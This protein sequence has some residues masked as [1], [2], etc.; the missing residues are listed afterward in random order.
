MNKIRVRIKS[1]IKSESCAFVKLESLQS[2]A[3][4]S[5]LLLDFSG[6]L[7]LGS[8]CSVVFK[9]SEVFIADKSYSKISARNRFVSNITAIERDEIFA[10]IYLAFEGK[11]ITSL[12]SKEASMELD[13]KKG[14]EVLWFVKANEVMIEF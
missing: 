12:I 7:T 8:E 11:N 1:V 2:N 5:A 14:D 13:L 4:F 3:V 6:N 9:E 10:R